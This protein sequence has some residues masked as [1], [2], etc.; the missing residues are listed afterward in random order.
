[1]LWIFFFFFLQLR[2]HTK[3]TKR[4]LDRN[5]RTSLTLRFD[6]MRQNKKKYK[7]KSIITTASEI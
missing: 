7:I 4:V 5:L 6:L 1:M 2:K 3:K